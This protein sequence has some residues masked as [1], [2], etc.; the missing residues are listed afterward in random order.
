MRTFVLLFWMLSSGVA[1]ATDLLPGGYIAVGPPKANVKLDRPTRRRGNAT[2]K[3]L[4]GRGQDVRLTV[5]AYH[6]GRYEGAVNVRVLYPAGTELA[7]AKVDLGRTATI[8]FAPPKVEDVLT[9]ECHAGLNAVG[10]L[11]EG[12]RLLIPAGEQ[13][14]RIISAANPLYFYVEKGVRSFPVNLAGQG[15]RETARAVVRDPDGKAVAEFDTVETVSRDV[16]VPVGAGMDGRVWSVHV[17]KAS[18]GR[19]EDATIKLPKGV[20][21]FVAERPG[22]LIVPALRLEAPFLV[23]A[24]ERDSVEARAYVAGSVAEAIAGMTL[25]VL[26]PGGKVAASRSLKPDGEMAWKPDASFRPGQYQIRLTGRLG[27][28][29]LV[30]QQNVQ[31][32]ARPKGLT[33]DKTTLVGGKPFFARGLYHVQAKDYELVRKQGFNIVQAG[34]GQIEAC[35]AAG[36]KAAV[37]LYGGMTVRPEH[38]REVITKYR[39]HPAVACWMTMDEPAAHGVPLD[40][41]ARGYA[42]IRELCDHPAYTC[43][44]R[45]DSYKDYGRCTDIIAIDVYPVGRGP[46]TAISDSLEIAKAT[47][48]RRTIWFIGQVWSWPNTRLVTPAEHR[49]MTYLALTHD[50]VRGLFW[51]SFRDP[52]WYLPESNRPVWDM[53]KRVNEELIRLEPVLLTNNAWERV[54]RTGQGEVHFAAKRHGGKLYVIATNPTEHAAELTVDLKGDGAGEAATE[55]F[56]DRRIK[57]TDGRLVERFGPLDTHVYVLTL[58]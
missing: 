48:S 56:E 6:V 54:A 8:E 41:L 50:D 4:P 34:P 5:H 20:G 42:T 49:C 52:K 47:A 28:Q 29:E 53:C 13:A 26:D 51:Y 31:V 11:A 15:D 23:R 21:P 24:D 45:P 16:D 27:D 25:S 12:G 58:K 39:D 30:R 22:D 55:V 57:L 7:K 18:R 1:E 44:C 14:V 37:V 46:L 35:Q 33:G 10:V 19:F 36:L 3:L 43:I 32:V 38:Y 2:Y 40:L 9:V 17:T